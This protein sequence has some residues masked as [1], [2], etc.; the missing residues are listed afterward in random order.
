M[1][2]P[3]RTYLT[4]NDDSD[5]GP[6]FRV[7]HTPGHVPGQLAFLITLPETG[8]VMLTSDAI[9]RPAEVTERFDTAHDPAA[10]ITSAARILDIA[11]QAGAMIIYGHCPEQWPALRKAPDAYL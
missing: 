2:W 5:I 11:E 7:Y 3:A 1:I 10:A 6:G 9:S 8:L 4:T